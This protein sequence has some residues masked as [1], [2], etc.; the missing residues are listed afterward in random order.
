MILYHGSYT[1]IETIDILIQTNKM[2]ITAKGSTMMVECNARDLA[3][4]A[5]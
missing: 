2:N 1:D 5:Y 4:H 3:I